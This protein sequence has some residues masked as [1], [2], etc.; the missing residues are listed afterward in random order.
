MVALTPVGAGPA[1]ALA[2]LYRATSYVFALL[3]C[4]PTALYV[5]ARV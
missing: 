1:A 2:L 4:G 3:V 5:T